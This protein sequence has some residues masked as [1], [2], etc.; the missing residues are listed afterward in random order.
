MKGFSMVDSTFIISTEELQDKIE[1]S[2][3]VTVINVLDEQYYQ[4]CHIKDSIN[5]PLDDLEE[6]VEDWD[7]EQQIV[8]YCAHEECTAS[9][10][11][12]DILKEMDFQDVLVYKEGMRAWYQEGFPVEGLCAESYLQ[13]ED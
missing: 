6:S 9:D 1:Q 7:K 11:A 3:F 12:F 13:K 10:E 8:V 5:I 2:S 4:D